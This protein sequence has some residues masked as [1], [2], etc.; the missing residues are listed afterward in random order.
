MTAGPSAVASG[1]AGTDTEG[2]GNPPVHDD[3]TEPDVVT[4]VPVHP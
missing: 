1:P 2:M 4:R 3:G